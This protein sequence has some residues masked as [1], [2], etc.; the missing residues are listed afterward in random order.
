MNE[1]VEVP[2]YG[3]VANGRVAL[4][5]END[6]PLVSQYRWHCIGD[7]ACTKVRKTSVLMHVL[8]MG[9]KGIDHIDHD[10][11]N[12]RRGN[13]RIATQSQN[14]ANQRTQTRFTTSKYKGVTWAVRQNRWKAQIQI[15]KRNN[16]LGYFTSEIE[17]AT[18]Y[19]TAAKEAWGEFA[20]PNFIK[21][22]N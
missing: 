16:H 18:T 9:V 10:G 3:V 7:Y 21:G 22:E 14:M 1:W 8:I 11:L 20:H 6:Y 13:L 17:A 5:D 4:V 15:D 2:L 12:N 19:D